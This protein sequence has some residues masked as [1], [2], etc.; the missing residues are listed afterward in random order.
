MQVRIDFNSLLDVVTDKKLNSIEDVAK[1]AK[2]S[3]ATVSKAF[4]GKPIA[5]RSATKL[6]NALGKDK[7]LQIWYDAPNTNINT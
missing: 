2:M 5:I 1:F 6:F 4:R 7:R 3:V